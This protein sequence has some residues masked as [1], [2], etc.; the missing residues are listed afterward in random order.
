MGWGD[1][2][3]DDEGRPIG[4]G[5]EATCDEPGCTA[6][7]D[8]GLSYCCGKEHGGGEWGCGRY[9]CGKH[10]SLA[11]AGEDEEI[12]SPQLCTSCVARWNAEV[13]VEKCSECRGSGISESDPS[14]A[15]HL[16]CPVCDGRGVIAY[17]EE[18]AR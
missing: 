3:T 13:V 5:V 7:I 4:Y 14:G 10:L 12:C 2:G 6:R 8:R 11:W 1:C 16:N 18:S 17:R 9:F 15:F